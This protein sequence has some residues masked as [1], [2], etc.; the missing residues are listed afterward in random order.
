[1]FSFLKADATEVSPRYTVRDCHGP[2]GLAMAMTVRQMFL[3][4]LINAQNHVP[5]IT[6]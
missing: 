6:D 3:Q 5:G 2:S 4:S 1:M